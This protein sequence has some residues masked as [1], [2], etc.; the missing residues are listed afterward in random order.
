MIKTAI[1]D[2]DGTLLDTSEF[3]YQAFDHTIQTHN[4]EFVTRK[5]VKKHMGM[6]LSEM[7]KIFAPQMDTSQ[8]VDTHREFQKRNLH[9]SK[10]Y[11]KV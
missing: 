2:L 11:L 1:F 3:I 5:E 7:Y 8:L 4:I 10:P 6:K 9:L